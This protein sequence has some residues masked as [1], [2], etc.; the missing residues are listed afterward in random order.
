MALISRVFKALREF[1]CVARH[2]GHTILDFSEC[3]GINTR[4]FGFSQMNESLPVNL[5][6]GGSQPSHRQSKKY[7]SRNC[8]RRVARLY[9]LST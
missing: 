8:D 7:R 4:Q 9:V 6:L 1:D 5:L 2:A 3:S